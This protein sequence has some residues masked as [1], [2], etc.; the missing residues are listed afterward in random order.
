MITW[1]DYVSYH[2][3]IDLM[4]EWGQWQIENTE[5]LISRSLCG[6]KSQTK[7]RVRFGIKYTASDLILVSSQTEF[8]AFRKPNKT[9]TSTEK[10]NKP[11]SSPEN[12]TFGHGCFGPDLSGILN[13]IFTSTPIHRNN[14]F[15]TINRLSVISDHSLWISWK[16]S[17]AKYHSLP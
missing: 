3:D 9:K 13:F 16:K 5:S 10:N 14:I 12:G 4:I 8:D 11:L 15:A 2:M 1:S 7:I 6:K 17:I